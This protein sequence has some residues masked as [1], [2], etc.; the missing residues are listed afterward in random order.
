MIVIHLL[1]QILPTPNEAFDALHMMMIQMFRF[2][3]R[4]KVKKQAS[5]CF[6]FLLFYYIYNSIIKTPNIPIFAIT[7]DEEKCLESQSQKDF[8]V[9]TDF[10]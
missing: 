3:N 1:L 10:N 9:S 2:K 7:L 8:K 4:L 6:F 5:A